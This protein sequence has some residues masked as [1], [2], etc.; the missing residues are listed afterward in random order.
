MNQDVQQTIELRE[1]DKYKVAALV[2]SL[3]GIM[4]WALIDNK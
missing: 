1:K 3:S 2:G 4:L